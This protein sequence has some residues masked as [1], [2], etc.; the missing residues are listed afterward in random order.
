VSSPDLDLDGKAEEEGEEN[1]PR[2]TLLDHLD[3]LRRRLLYS[4]IA[5]FVAFLGSW[6]FAPDVFHWLERP[7]L[8]VLPEGEQLAFTELS[9][10]FML[11]IKVAL[12]TAIFVASP[13]LLLQ[14]WL[15]L[16]PGLYRR[17]RRLAVPFVVFTSLFFITGGYFG[18]LVAF[19]M[20]VRFL[21]GVGE[22]FKQVVTIGTYFSMMSKI[23]MGLGLVFEMPMLIFFLARI[24]LVNAR[25]LLRWFRWAVLLIFVIAAVIT[26]TPD[27]ATQTVFAVPMI[28]LY[29]IGV[30]VAAM[31]GKK[32]DDLD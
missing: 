25:Q 8:E 27:V 1:L 4:V 14:L 24:G 9:A 2:M 20:V 3:E 7:I 17:E 15:F 21:L 16:K 5:L 31:F 28:L 23:L 12:L 26:P 22:D 11:Y 30:A 29:L 18:Y 13:F 19:P 32:R 6:Y 10:P